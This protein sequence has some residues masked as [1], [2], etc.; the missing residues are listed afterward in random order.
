VAVAVAVAVAV[1]GFNWNAENIVAAK[2]YYE[3]HLNW[4][5]VA[6]PCVRLRRARAQRPSNY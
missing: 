2:K 4:K 6:S 3:R 5:S 1:T